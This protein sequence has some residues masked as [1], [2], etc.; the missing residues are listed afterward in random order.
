MF[1]AE[2]PPIVALI[3]GSEGGMQRAVM[4]SYDWTTQT[5]YHETILRMETKVL[6]KMS[7]VGKVRFGIKRWSKPMR[8]SHLLP[9]DFKALESKAHLPRFS[10]F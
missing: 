2:R 7:R 5:V 4:C 10:R 9:M 8:D 3:C 6:E 1:E